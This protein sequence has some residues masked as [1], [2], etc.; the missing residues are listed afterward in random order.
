MGSTGSTAKSRSQDPSS[1]LPG[2]NEDGIHEKSQQGRRSS[3]RNSIDLKTNAP[4]LEGENGALEKVAGMPPSTGSIG[5]NAISGGDRTTKMRLLRAVLNWFKRK[6]RKEIKQELRNAQ[7][8]IQLNINI[9]SEL[10]ITIQGLEGEVE[11]TKQA[12][13]DMAVKHE[14]T[15]EVSRQVGN[16]RQSEGDT[17]DLR[18]QLR[19]TQE[20]LHRATELLNQRTDELKMVDTYLSR[21]NKY[22]D[23]EL[24]QMVEKLNQE[25]SQTCSAI[26]DTLDFSTTHRGVVSDDLREQLLPRFSQC[27]PAAFLVDLSRQTPFPDDETGELRIYVALQAVMIAGV[28]SYSQSWC[29]SDAVIAKFLKQMYQ[30]LRSSDPFTAPRWRAMSRSQ[31]R[32]QS[33]SNQEVEACSLGLSRGIGDLLSLCGWTSGYV[34]PK[35]QHFAR[36]LAVIATK[37]LQLNQALLEGT[38]DGEVELLWFE[39]GWI[40]DPDHATSDSSNSLTGKSICTTDLGLKVASSG[41]ASKTILKAKV[42]LE[43]DFRQN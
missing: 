14:S 35:M 11:Q 24:K 13:R 18:N 37:T 38:I 23:I 31:V 22:S 41:G 16:I 17:D 39:A 28:H 20:Q 29:P 1:G 19:V 42:M 43:D 21:T 10:K 34:E 9:I 2:T 40:C 7:Q 36:N 27:L 4:E 25:I 33:S 30:G 15:K 12:L 3:T 6:S 26:V 8:E 5:Q 32:Q